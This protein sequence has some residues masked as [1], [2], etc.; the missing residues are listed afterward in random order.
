MNDIMRFIKKAKLNPW[1]IGPYKI[2][3]G[4]SKVFYELYFPNELASVY[5]V[6]YVSV[7]KKC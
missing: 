4:I 7:I 6:I 5:P 3:K 1:H 2:L